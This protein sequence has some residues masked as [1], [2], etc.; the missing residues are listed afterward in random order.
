[1]ISPGKTPS[2]F[3]KN[4]NRIS[5]LVNV[6]SVRSDCRYKNGLML[7]L[8]SSKDLVAIIK[9]LLEKKV[10]MKIDKTAM[11]MAISVKMA[12]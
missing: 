9:L 12:R 11:A 7:A 3:S 10:A 1:M 5:C 6:I 2:F 4:S 8:V